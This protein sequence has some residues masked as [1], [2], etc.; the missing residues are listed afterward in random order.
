MNID[1]SK[2]D[3]AN[4]TCDKC[5]VCGASLQKRQRR[6]HISPWV[7]VLLVLGAPLWLP[8][9]IAVLSVIFV[10]YISVW[11]VIISLFAVFGAF[12]VSALG[13]VLSGVLLTVLGKALPGVFLIGVGFIF[14]GF[15][16]FMFFIGAAAAKGVCFLTKITFRAFSRCFR[17][18]EGAL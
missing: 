10:V 2:A 7:I 11:S 5:S 8:V 6:G 16:V 17:K 1:T 4:E 12:V 14:A 3:T 18:K 15:S 9:L 13:G